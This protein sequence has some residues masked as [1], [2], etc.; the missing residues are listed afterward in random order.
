MSY[1]TPRKR[2]SHPDWQYVD[3]HEPTRAD[4]WFNPELGV[5]VLSSV[6]IAETSKGTGIAMPHW[7]VSASQLW[8]KVGICTDQHM[9]R[10][11]AD[12]GMGGAH[13]DNHGKG[14]VRHLWLLGGATKEEECACKQDEERTV[15]GD[16]VRHDPQEAKP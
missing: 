4:R 3:F 13:E 7:H 6:D 5:F 9:E 15:E 12:F 8:P 14:K 2:P 11:R 16:R 10:V 1:K